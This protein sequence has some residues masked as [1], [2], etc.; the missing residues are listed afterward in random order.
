MAPA[1]GGELWRGQALP[2]RPDADREDFVG[3]V[4][5]VTTAPARTVSAW[6][7]LAKHPNSQFQKPLAYTLHHRFI[8]G[9]ILM[10]DRLQHERP[11]LFLVA[12]C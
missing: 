3:R 7:A 2:A 12:V 6:A 5:T 1:A 8:L 9:F 4:A 10:T 11:P